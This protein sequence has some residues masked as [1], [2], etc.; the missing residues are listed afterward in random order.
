LTNRVARYRRDGSS[1]IVSPSEVSC[2]FGRSSG[3]SVRY[4]ETPGV[5]SL[6]GR[7]TVDQSASG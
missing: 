4:Q 3:T 6:V 2:P 5:V 7:V 1:L